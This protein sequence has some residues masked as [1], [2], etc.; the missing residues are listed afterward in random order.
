MKRLIS[1]FFYSMHGLRAAWI[2]EMAFKQEVALLFVL[3]PLAVYLAPSRI[4]LVLML[5]S[6]GLVI[7][8]ELLNSALEAAIDRIGPEKH[9]LSKKA[10]DLGSAAVFITLLIAVMTWL[11]LLV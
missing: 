8:T 7:V 1:A 11:L 10:K 3:V 6:C 5:S 2:D 4:A 9:P